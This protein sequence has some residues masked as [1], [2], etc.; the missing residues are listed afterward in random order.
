MSREG[1]TGIVYQT[2]KKKK[3]RKKKYWAVDSGAWVTVRERVLNETGDQ[4][5]QGG[6]RDT[7]KGGLSGG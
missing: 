1:V 6:P 7:Q 5:P 3:E 4:V 2:P